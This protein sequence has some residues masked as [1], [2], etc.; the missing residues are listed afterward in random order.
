[1]VR[2]GF[3]KDEDMDV[4]KRRAANRAGRDTTTTGSGRRGVPSRAKSGADKS[5]AAADR[6]MSADDHKMMAQHHRNLAGHHAAQA[7]TK[8][9]RGKR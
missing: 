6:R 3:A 5:L 9:G 1:M 4:I 2:V 7:K 8:G